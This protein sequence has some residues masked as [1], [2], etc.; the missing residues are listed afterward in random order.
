MEVISDLN[1]ISLNWCANL[2]LSEKPHLADAIRWMTRRA[3]GQKVCL[4]DDISDYWQSFSGCFTNIVVACFTEY[5][6]FAEVLFP[7][8]YVKG[9]STPE[10][11]FEKVCP[12]LKQKP[13]AHALFPVMSMSSKMGKS[14]LLEATVLSLTIAP[15]LLE[16]NG[17]NLLAKCMKKNWM[18]P[19]TSVIESVGPMLRAMNVNWKAPPYVNPTAEKAGRP[20]GI[21]CCDRTDY[22][23]G[24]FVGSDTSKTEFQ[25]SLFQVKHGRGRYV[26]VHFCL[27]TSL[28]LIFFSSDLR[29]RFC[30]LTSMPSFVVISTLSQRSTCRFT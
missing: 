18:V 8:R 28:P 7:G 29:S 2:E 20:E 11:L 30:L 22:H 13:S 23:E 12:D 16:G 26:H 4:S 14:P 19:L 9:T 17:R 1:K 27:K 6:P 15:F 10:E 3:V 21:E 25:K 5:R 24:T